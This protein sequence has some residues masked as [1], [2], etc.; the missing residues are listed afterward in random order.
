MRFSGPMVASLLSADDVVLSASS[1]CVAFS[2][3]CMEQGVSVDLEEA[4]RSRSSWHL[5]KICP[6]CLGRGHWAGQVPGRDT[7][8]LHWWVGGWD[9]NN[10]D[11]FI[12][13]S[14]A[15]STAQMVFSSG[16]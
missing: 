1:V 2:A 14:A 10:K 13:S 8:S 4:A 16:M 9:A 7:M 15:V 11:G 12:I 6:G 3:H 5:R